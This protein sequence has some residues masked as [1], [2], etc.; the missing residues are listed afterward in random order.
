MTRALLLGLFTAA[1]VCG[2]APVPDPREQLASAVAAEKA[3]RT[4][5]AIRQLRALLRSAPPREIA[6]QA[7]LELVRI[8]QS[9]AEW[10]E[11]AEQ[12]RELRVLAP[13]D[14]EYAYQ[15]GVVYRN[16]SKWAFEKMQRTAP[17][18]A[19]SQQ[20]LGEQFSVSG[21]VAKAVSAFR[22]AIAADE[23]LTG[24]HLALAVIL[25]RQN[26]RDQ[27][28]AEIDQEL[29]LAPESAIAK[30]VRQAITGSAP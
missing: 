26:N 3:G 13:D 2:Q 12:L 8:H 19:R 17:D 27:A 23:K 4:E 5:S 15:L 7:R 10:W 30:Q 29:R 25:L 18:S 14:A 6:G 11:A 28:L 1:L 9:R 24:S 20:M 22:L 16:L 21:D